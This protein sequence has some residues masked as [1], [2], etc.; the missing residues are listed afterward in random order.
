MLNDN[1]GFIVENLD[2]NYSVNLVCLDWLSGEFHLIHLSTHQSNDLNIFMNRQEQEKFMLYTRRGE[3]VHC[4]QACELIK[5]KI[6]FGET[7]YS[8]TYYWHYS[9]D[10]LVSCA[11]SEI[12]VCFLE[13]LNRS[14]VNSSNWRT[15]VWMK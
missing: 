11:N 9:K 4:Y 13:E 1:I 15:F 7:F 12:E 3:H 14:F 2:N 6:V 10:K 5:N 8:S